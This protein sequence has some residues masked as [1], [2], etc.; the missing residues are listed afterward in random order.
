MA[1]ESAIALLHR[2]TVILFN[3]VQSTHDKVSFRDWLSPDADSSLWDGAGCQ[4]GNLD[5]ELSALYFIQRFV[6]K[7]WDGVVAKWTLVLKCSSEHLFHRINPC[8]IFRSRPF[9]STLKAML[10]KRTQDNDLNALQALAQDIGQDSS[11]WF[12]FI[13]LLQS[14]QSSLSKTRNHLRAL[15][16]EF[17]SNKTKNEDPLKDILIELKELEQK[18]ADDFQ[19]QTKNL[20]ALVSSPCLSCIRLGSFVMNRLS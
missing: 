11:T 17:G 5:T 16:E 9:L 12:T 8:S 1:W 20:T 13:G 18:V 6:A 2:R 4:M 7:V 19:D 15:I 3:E 14:Q 10:M